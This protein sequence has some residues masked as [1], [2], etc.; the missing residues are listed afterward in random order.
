MKVLQEV[1]MVGEEVLQALSFLGVL[2]VHLGFSRC[3][4]EGLIGFKGF[5]GW[6][7]RF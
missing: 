5:H 7:R 3:C 2:V 6:F 1:V 4:L